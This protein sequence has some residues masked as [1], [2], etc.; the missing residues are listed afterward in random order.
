MLSYFDFP[1]GKVSLKAA[2]NF[3]GSHSKPR[4]SGSNQDWDTEAEVQQTLF[5]F[6]A[7]SACCSAPPL[8]FP[9]SPKGHILCSPFFFSV[10]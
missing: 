3:C 5:R 8:I 6:S 2:R 10:S 4:N 1:K 7:E 9:L